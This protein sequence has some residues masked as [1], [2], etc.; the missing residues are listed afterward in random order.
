MEV[1]VIYQFCSFG[2]V[3]RVILNRAKALKKKGQRVHITVCYLKDYGALQSFQEY[4]R[5]NSLS[6]LISAFLLDA[7]TL[8]DLKKYDLVLNIDTPQLFEQTRD[9]RSFFV[10]C[11]TPYTANRQYLMNLPPNV[12]GILV[13]TFAFK[14]IL[15]DEFVN[16]PPIT[17][18]PNPV[19]EEFFSIPFETNTIYPMRPL[20]YLAR[21]D[22]LKNYVEALDVFELFSEDESV[23]FAIVGRAI[24]LTQRRLLSLLRRKGIVGKT[25]VRHEIGFEA[26]PDLIRLI[27]SHRGI[28]ISPSLGESFGL[29][30]AEFMSA[31]VPVV[32]SNISVHRELVNEDERFLYKT[33]GAAS[34]KDK[35]TKILADWEGASDRVSGYAKKFSGEAF[36]SSWR[37]LAM[38]YDISSGTW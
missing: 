10:E 11:H 22:E 35:V 20:A 2:G 31:G 13:P 19:S 14:N 24:T 6:E 36:L 29:S 21:L 34:A 27:K 4:I 23:M 30:A 26:V 25:F 1:L 28:F 16:L 3:E 15:L 12:V 37:E 9:A 18:M 5:Q 38:K 17:V 33:G 7:A 8:L 32:L